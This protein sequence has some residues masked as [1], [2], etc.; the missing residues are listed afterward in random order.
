MDLETM[1][2]TKYSGVRKETNKEKTDSEA[3]KREKKRI[4]K[5]R[6]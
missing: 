1:K 5:E 3:I 6:K 4:R 2:E